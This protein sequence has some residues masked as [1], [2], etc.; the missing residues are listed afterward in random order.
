MA[1]VLYLHQYF[2]TPEEGGAIRSYYLAKALVEAGH[3]VVLITAHNHPKE[4][5]KTIEGIE[6]HYLPVFYENNLSKSGR[7]ISF[8]K[9]MF[10]CIGKSQELHRN[11]PFDICYATST[12]LTIGI[13]ALWLKFRNRI[14]YL[15][16]VRDLWPEAAIQMGVIKSWFWKWALRKLESSIYH[17]AKGLVALSPGMAEGMNQVVPKRKVELIPNMSDTS[18]F[19]LQKKKVSTPI[20]ILYAGSMGK[21]NDLNR[22][23]TTAQYLEKRKIPLQITMVG[24]GS[25]K[26]QLK[27][28]I[29][30]LK[31]TSVQLIASS[32]KTQIK[33]LLN[34]HD[35]V[36]ISFKN[37]PILQ[38]NSPNKFFDAIAAGKPCIINIEGWIADLIREHNMGCVYSEDNLEVLE[39]F[40]SQVL[41]Q[42]DRFYNMGQNARKLA[43][44]QFDRK[45]LSARLVALVERAVQSPN[46]YLQ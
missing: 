25:E 30:E 18:F 23:L 39:E 2:H 8:I 45:Q 35:L 13:P 32:N 6:V 14:P 27:H 20:R 42:P 5:T 1:R 17:N 43:E 44:E 26:A 9:F 33:N 40:L 37:I 22:L 3:E 10:R 15:F 38:T 36:F 46:K 21:S 16:E 41:Q 28:R 24:K 19:S 12:P 29:E 31:L 34:E 7:I 11:Q 4:E